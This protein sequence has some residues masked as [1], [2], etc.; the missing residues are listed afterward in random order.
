M[1]ALVAIVGRPNVG[2]ST[3]FNR[4]IHRRVALVE[5]EPGVTRDRHYAEAEYANR[6]FTLVD[7]GGFVPDEKDSLQNQVREQAQLAV[8]ECDAIILVV[9]GRAGLTAGDQDVARYLR[10]S[11]KP[12]FVAVNKIDD[13]R[14]QAGISSDFFKLGLGEVYEISAE[15]DRGVDVLMD[16]AVE[17]LPIAPDDPEVDDSSRELKELGPEDEAPKAPA[18]VRVAIVGR[19]NVGKSTLVNALL[20]KKRLITSDVAGTT[21]DPIDTELQFK[22]RRFVLT[23]TAGIRRKATVSHRVEQF[24]VLSA[25][26]AIDRSDVAVL[27][28]D[29]TEHA[30]EQ[31]ARIAGIAEEKTRALL[32]VVNKWDKVAKKPGMEE[33]FR[34]ELKLRLKFVAWAP[35]IFTSALTGSKVEKV[36]ELASQLYAQY[37]FRAPTPRLNK[38]LEHITTEHPAPFHD[39]KALR[40][41]Y[42]AQVGVAPPAFAFV[43][44][45]PT[46]IPDQ[47]K[48]YISNQLRQTFDLNV[49]IR[50]FFRE[51]PGGKKRQERL[52]QMRQAKKGRVAGKGGRPTTKKPPRGEKPDPHAKDRG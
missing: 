17:K 3:L 48:R 45:R 42:V 38:L 37:H 22:G 24:A 31:D 7:T 27:L 16:A 30:V 28:L 9:D 15:H 21:R 13:P 51:R 33:E 14:G 1:G 18:T 2:K 6:R 49:P 47:Y 20:G 4:L 32:I 19:P 36:L 5:N 25:L 40:I 50:L 46:Q 12:T 34:N 39:G 44:N 52:D 11:G 43:C 26:K 8:E 29:A 41:Y 23:D 10:K 35:V